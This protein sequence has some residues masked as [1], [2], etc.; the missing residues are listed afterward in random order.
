MTLAGI[1]ER[2]NC[3]SPADARALRRGVQP[4]HRHGGVEIW[5]AIEG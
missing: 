4:Q 5:I 3:Q 1:G 2:Y